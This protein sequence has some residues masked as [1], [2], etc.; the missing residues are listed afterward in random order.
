VKLTSLPPPNDEETE[1][2]VIGEIVE[3]IHVAKGDAIILV[4]ACTIRHYVRDE[5]A[6]LIDRTHFPT[7]SGKMPFLFCLRD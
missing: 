4:D 5:V 1:K 6:D 7:Y 3:M 2:A